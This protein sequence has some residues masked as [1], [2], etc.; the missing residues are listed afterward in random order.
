MSTPHY[1]EFCETHVERCEKCQE[2]LDLLSDQ[3]VVEECLDFQNELN[4]ADAKAQMDAEY[5]QEANPRP[6]DVYGGKELL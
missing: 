3:F 1:D 5:E 6:E 4:E 2:R